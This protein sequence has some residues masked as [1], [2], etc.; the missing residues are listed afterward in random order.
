MPRKDII[1]KHGLRIGYYKYNQEH[2]GKLKIFTQSLFYY[3]R[4][5]GELLK[6]KKQQCSGHIHK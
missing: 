6:K 1:G 5:I 3:I 2:K 4:L